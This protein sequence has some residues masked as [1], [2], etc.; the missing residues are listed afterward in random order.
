MCQNVTTR[1]D[2][3]Y[4]KQKERGEGDGGVPE[5]KRGLVVNRCGQSCT[6]MFARGARVGSGNWS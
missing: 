4:E 5:R 2:D 1:L 3:I 6:S